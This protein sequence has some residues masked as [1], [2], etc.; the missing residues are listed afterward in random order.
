MAKPYARIALFQNPAS[1]GSETRARDYLRQRLGDLADDLEE[2]VVTPDLGVTA[3][4]QDLAKIGVNLVAV[5]GGDGTVREVATGLVKTSVPLAIIP[6]GT[7]NNLALSLGLPRTPEAVCDLIEK[8]D[9]KTIDVGL[10]DEHHYFFEAAGVGVDAEL[11]PM[12]E[13]VKQGKLRGLLR[14]LSLAAKHSQLPVELSFDRPV[15]AAYLQSFR[16]QTS[17]R[18]LR[19]RFRRSRQ[20]VKLR[21]S[22]VAVGNGPYY[23]GN[24]TICPGAS[25]DDGLLRIAVYRDFS[26]RELLTHLWSISRGRYQ[27]SPKLELFECRTLEVR[28]RHRLFVHVDGNPIGTTPVRFGTIERGLTVFAPQSFA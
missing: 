16:G 21:C 20:R 15:A 1:G 24:F 10:A 2:I 4:A 5:A 17:V 25:L 27:Y 12:G 18:H 19:K 26:K 14:A 7:F 22:F 9:T 3:R 28:S 8:G 13:E 11:F 23:G 6:L